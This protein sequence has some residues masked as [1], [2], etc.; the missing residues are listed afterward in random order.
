M[1]VR[2]IE[3]FLSACDTDTYFEN[4][5]TILMFLKYYCCVSYL[6][7]YKIIYF[8]MNN[9]EKYFLFLVSIKTVRKKREIKKFFDCE[10]C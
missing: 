7:Y 5:Q 2:T 6:K 4:I 3:T 10:I 8:F 1:R 9:D